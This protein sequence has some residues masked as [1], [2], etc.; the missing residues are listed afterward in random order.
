MSDLKDALERLR[1]DVSGAGLAPAATVR[2][3]ADRRRLVGWAA[4]P[5]ATAL[6]A[7]AVLMPSVLLTDSEGAG[8]PPVSVPPATSGPSPDQPWLPIPWRVDSAQRTSLSAAGTAGD[9]FCG[10]A[11]VEGDASAVRQSLADGA[12]AVRVYAI[13]TPSF[14]RASSLF[15]RLYSECG[16]LGPVSSEQGPAM[17]WQLE[18]EAPA[19]A[20]W[21]NTTIYLVVSGQPGDSDPPLD[22]RAVVAGLI[23]TV[24]KP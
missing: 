17:Y 1:T 9:D 8:K 10:L 12:R 7:A 13:A 21:D 6:V 20:L 15:K 18:G 24:V 3:N 4:V 16:A 11:E 23:D 2:R 14:A 19:A 5:A 22:L